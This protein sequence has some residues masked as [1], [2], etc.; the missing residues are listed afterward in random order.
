MRD[1]FC[2]KNDPSELEK[3]LKQIYDEDYNA[4]FFERREHKEF[5]L[6][7]F[8][9]EQKMDEFFGKLCFFL[10]QNQSYDLVKQFFDVCYIELDREV[11][12]YIL[13]P[14]ECKI[15]TKLGC[16][17]QTS[18]S[19]EEY[20]DYDDLNLFAHYRHDKH[21]LFLLKISDVE[22]LLGHKIVNISLY[23]KWKI[24]GVLIY[25][26][27][28]LLYALFIIFFTLNSTQLFKFNAFPTGFG[29]ITAVLI[30]IILIYEAF[31]I[32]FVKLSYFFA[33]THYFEWV[34]M[35]LCLMAIFWP[36]DDSNMNVKTSFYSLSLL[37][38]Y[39]NLI[40]RTEKSIIFGTYSYAFRKILMKSLRVLPIVLNLFL[41]FY[42]AFKIRSRY[43]TNDGESHNTNEIA[44]FDSSLSLGLLRLSNMFMGNM[45]LSA[46]GLALAE[47]SYGADSNNMINYV[48]VSGFIFLMPIFLFN[49]FIGIAVGEVGNMVNKG[50]YHL[51]KARIDVLLRIFYVFSFF[52]YFNIK[53]IRDVQTRKYAWQTP[54]CKDKNGILYYI[55]HIYW[56]LKDKL[57]N[58]K[59]SI[60]YRLRTN[61]EHDLA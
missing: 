4:K 49:L 1:R 54:K 24:F 18:A 23:N 35:I 58:S 25:N 48:L 47:N 34:N 28:M 11:Y 20:D 9:S 39:L 59:W 51:V 30:I 53:Y 55:K 32:F 45:D 21:P 12:F 43:L 60:S 26:F 8:S 15:N 7:V 46:L 44:G 33:F 36:S 42:F 38:A 19:I 57:T 52:D 17:S 16:C 29:S 27:E 6:S 5:L 37:Y 22:D 61:G 41:G 10:L 31:H 2:I 50:A 13:T 40:F 14:I 3:K 56:I